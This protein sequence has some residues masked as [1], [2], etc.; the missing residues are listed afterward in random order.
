MVDTQECL[1]PRHVSFTTVSI[2]K[3]SFQSFSERM[4]HVPTGVKYDVTID[5]VLKDLNSS[6]T[7]YLKILK[8]A[9]SLK[10]HVL[11]NNFHLNGHWPTALI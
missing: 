9:L 2:C 8:R 1:L 10:V 3:P 11:L 5:L 4:L 7:S 6:I